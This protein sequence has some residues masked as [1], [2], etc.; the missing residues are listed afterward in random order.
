M[1]STRFAD[2]DIRR[3][4]SRCSPE[5]L[6]HNLALVD[7]VKSW[8]ERKNA[9]PARMETTAT[10]VESIVA[11]FHLLDRFPGED[12]TRLVALLK[13]LAPAAGRAR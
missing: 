11:R 5:N 7:L 10:A 6:P 8:A 13:L 2:G 9:T 4:E 1:A 3:V 12:R